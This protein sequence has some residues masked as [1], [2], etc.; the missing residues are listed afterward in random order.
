M[1]C[2]TYKRKNNKTLEIKI[3]QET[4]IKKGEGRGGQIGYGKRGNDM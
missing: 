4:W 2:K 3:K 1:L